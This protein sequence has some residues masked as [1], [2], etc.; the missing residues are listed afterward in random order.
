MPEDE[1][2]DP[3]ID[4]DV[5]LRVPGE[6]A[7]LHASGRVVAAVALGGMVGAVVRFVIAEAWPTS[8]FPWATFGVN[9][10]GCFGIGALMAWLTDRESAHPLL[11]PF[12]GTGLLGGYTTFSTYA[13]E[14]EAL[15]GS[16]PALGFAYLAASVLLGLAAA[17]VG[18]AM[19]ARRRDS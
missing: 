2:L 18:W 8:G 12:L 4:P 13:V 1:P 11:R 9:L 7:E 15:L 5:D 17:Y 3:G 19:L 14:A 16:R 6:R 10:T